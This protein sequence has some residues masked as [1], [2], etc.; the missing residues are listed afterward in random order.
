MKELT[1]FFSRLF[2]TSD[3]PPRWHCGK[4]TDLHGWTYIISDL[5]I[6]SA[7]FAIPIVI[8]QFISKRNDIKFIRLYFLFAAFILTCGI[9]HLLDAIS[10]WIPAYRLNALARLI[11]GI[12]SWTTV[13]Y[14]IKNLPVAFSL[15]SQEALEIEI[16]QRKAAEEKYRILNLELSNRIEERTAE[17]QKLVREN[18]QY[19]YALEESC[20]VAITDQ[21]GIIKYANQNFCNISK[22]SREELLG[23]DHQIINSGFHQKDF[24]RELW[25]TIANGKIWRGEIK[26]KAKDGSVYWVD[27]TIVPFLD[28]QNKPFQYIAIRADISSRKLV[29]ENLV[30]S[31]KEVSDYKYALDESSIVAITDQR[32]IIKYVNENFCKISKYSEEELIGQ[33]HKIINSGYHEKEFFRELWRTIARG[34]IW[35]GELKNK[36]KDGSAYWVDTTIIPFLDENN[37]PY[38]YVAIR[39]DITQ[40]KIAE[41]ENRTLNLELEN[42]VK[43]RTDE[44]ESFSYSV[45]HDLRT[46]LRAINGYAKILEEDYLKNFDQEGV[47]LLGE[48]QKN[49]KKMGVLIDNLLSFARLGKKELRKSEID[50]NQLVASILAD[51]G[52]SEDLNVDV[53]IQNLHPVQADRVLMTQVLTNLISNAI[54]YS[55]KQKNAEVEITSEKQDG[56]IIYSV[57]DN[58]VGFDMEYIDKLFGVFQRLHSQEEFTGT[59]VGLAI[60]KRIIQ[61]HDGNIWAES[62]L[63]NGAKFYFSLPTD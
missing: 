4:W 58:G 60:A 19:K 27:T 33:D 13:Y 43:E 49:A 57:Q 10:F 28:E 16:E 44:L 9:T 21:K 20:I 54:K 29:E 32:G 3:W 41:E 34:N 25:T 36:A 51:M 23:K 31:L 42:R 26:N 59:G 15:R 47:R 56:E 1:E 14:I 30:N 40:R 46:P 53:K 38:Q 5:M 37:K 63:G 22:F 39:S 17:L 2:D 61:K 50:M 12:L 62:R 24:I 52:G 55:S 6:W 35:R 18:Y 8:L 7:Y 11:T 48:V 45:S